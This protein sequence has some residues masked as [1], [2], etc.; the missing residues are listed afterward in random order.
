MAGRLGC[1]L[2]FALTAPGVFA[3]QVVKVK[4]KGALINLQGDSASPGDSFYAMDGGKKK[5]LLKVTK[6]KGD[7]AIARIVKGNAAAGMTTAPGPAGGGSGSATASPSAAE[8]SSSESGHSPH[9]ASA[10]RSYWGG[11]AGFAMDSMKVNVNRSQPP[12]DSL[13]IFPL[14]GSGFSAKG[15]FDY[16]LFNQVWF[17]GMFGVEMFNVAGDAKCSTGNTKTCDA[18]IMYLS[19]DFIGRYVFA[20]GN[21]RPWLG[22][23]IALLFP[24]SKSSTALDAASIGTTN[25][26]L[27]SGGLDW[28]I[29]PTMYIPIQVEYGMLPKSNEVDAHWI[30]VRAGLAVPF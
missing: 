27:P 7:K 24:A 6:V 21:F 26:I 19:G 15:L 9:S 14:A 12:R 22:L 18:K 3:G 28:F 30:A 5:A 29:S 2:V 4:G 16:E 8:S 11:M 13:G 25:V 23:G 17:R 10:G 20:M 1:L